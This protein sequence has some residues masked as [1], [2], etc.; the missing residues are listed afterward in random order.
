MKQQ[1]ALS[2]AIHAMARP[3]VHVADDLTLTAGPMILAAIEDRII[4]TGICR[5]GLSGGSTPAPIYA[6]LAEHVPHNWYSQLRITWVDE[7]HLPLDAPTG[8][9]EWQSFHAESNLR[10]AYQHWL[11]D[12][13][14]EPSQVLPMSLGGAIG[15][16]VVRFGRT[17]MA[18]FSGR[19]DVTI[20]GVGPDGHIASIFPDHPGMQVDDVCFAVHDSPKPPRERISLALPVLNSSDFTFVLARGEAKSAMLEL[21]YD[22]SQELPLSRLR[23]QGALH[24]VVDREA[25]QKI[26]A[27]WTEQTS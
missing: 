9:G 5:L 23:P 10:L 8:P 18:Q 21:A 13:P 7:R 22:G 15:A 24:W 25:G 1:R 12:A 27:R 11:K 16:Q 14:I 26:V 2:L 17:F 3:I 6:W 4:K 19:L 20:I